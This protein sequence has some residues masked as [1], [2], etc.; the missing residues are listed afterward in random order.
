MIRAIL[1]YLL[2]PREVALSRSPLDIRPLQLG[3][4]PIVIQMLDQVT[5]AL[6]HKDGT[7]VQLKDSSLPLN[8]FQNLVAPT[9]NIDDLVCLVVCR[10]YAD[11]FGWKRPKT[12]VTVVEAFFINDQTLL[13]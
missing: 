10:A 1:H 8:L 3:K 7:L 11:M 13:T 2:D 4:A 12:I 5:L 6:M 9:G